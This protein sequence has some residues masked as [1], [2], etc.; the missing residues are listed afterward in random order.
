M[1]DFREGG[2]EGGVE[3]GCIYPGI[4]F[5]LQNIPRKMKEIPSK[6]VFVTKKSSKK[7]ACGGHLGKKHWILCNLGHPQGRNTR[8]SGDS[9]EE[10]LDIPRFWGWILSGGEIDQGGDL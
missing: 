2:R 3:D 6:F 7:S 10:A 4:S 9:G 1:I 5:F 8:Y